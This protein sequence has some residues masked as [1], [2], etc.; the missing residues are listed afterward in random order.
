MLVVE[1]MHGERCNAY[2]H[3]TTQHIATS[4]NETAVSIG[5]TLNMC[6]CMDYCKWRHSS[7]FCGLSKVYGW[8]L[9]VCYVVCI[10][11]PL[12][13]TLQVQVMLSNHPQP[14][15]MRTSQCV[16]EAV[17]CNVFIILWLCRCMMV[18]LGWNNCWLS[19]L[20]PITC[21]YCIAFIIII[22]TQ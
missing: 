20:Q 1:Y 22:A 5:L 17:N 8:S 11:E 10:L 6:A 15:V 12:P 21:V 14:V 7:S 4:H 13:H 18:L 3:K 16:V 19:W 2:L 9:Y